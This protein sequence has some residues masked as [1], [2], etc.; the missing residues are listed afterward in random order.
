MKKKGKKGKEMTDKIDPTILGKKYM[1]NVTKAKEIIKQHKSAR[2]FFA[3]T[4]GDD[5]ANEDDITVYFATCYHCAGIFGIQHS[6]IDKTSEMQFIYTC[7]YCSA[8]GE[9]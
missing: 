9:I 8:K 5:I 4:T 7:P 6:F 3:E 1:N 2:K